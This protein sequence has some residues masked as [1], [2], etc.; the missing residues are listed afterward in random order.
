MKKYIL[1]VII[2]CITGCG[3]ARMTTTIFD[4][5]GNVVSKNEIKYTV[6]G[7]RKLSAIDIDIKEGRAKIGK[8]SGSSGAMGKI[9]SSIAKVSAGATGKKLVPIK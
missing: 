8:Q 1:I 7:S 6:I 4:N 3:T 9:L 2:C 5:E